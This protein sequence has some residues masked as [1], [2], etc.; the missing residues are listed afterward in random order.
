MKSPPPSS[1]TSGHKLCVPTMADAVNF[2]AD[3]RILIP[4]KAAPLSITNDDDPSIFLLNFAS[5]LQ[6]NTYDAGVLGHYFHFGGGVHVSTGEPHLA[7]FTGVGDAI[8][9]AMKLTNGTPYLYGITV[10]KLIAFC[11]DPPS[12]PG[13]VV[14]EAK[15]LQSW[16]LPHDNMEALVPLVDSDTHKFRQMTDVLISHMPLFKALKIRSIKDMKAWASKGYV[17]NMKAVLTSMEKAERVDGKAK[18][19]RAKDA[20]ESAALGAD[21]GE[22]WADIK[23]SLLG[24]GKFYEDTLSDR[25]IQIEVDAADN[26][27][28][29]EHI[30]TLEE[31]LK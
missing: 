26:L 12:R 29:D 30:S 13:D 24:V 16:K 10:E 11:A 27:P 23:A 1:A 6:K 9:V 18:G 31:S 15:F 7:K 21:G 14:D 3:G 19:G 2:V 20:A 17:S 22:R 4:N 5:V 28:K 8:V 25:I